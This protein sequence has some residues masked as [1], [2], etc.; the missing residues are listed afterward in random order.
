[1]PLREIET[2]HL[3]RLQSLLRTPI[4]AKISIQLGVFG[5]HAQG[6]LAI[7]L[8]GLVI[9]WQSREPWIVAILTIAFSQ[10]VSMVLKRLVRRRRPNH[11]SLKKSGKIFSELSFP[12]SHSMSSATA[13]FVLFPLV[14]FVVGLILIVLGTGI[15]F[16]RLII[17]AHFPTD[18]IAGA[19]MGIVIGFASQVLFF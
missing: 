15:L 13:V 17:A 3:I 19:I 2:N 4:A 16:S 7:G 11:S 10:L 8:I 1:M 6:W 14:P 9:N 5:E 18:V 12:S